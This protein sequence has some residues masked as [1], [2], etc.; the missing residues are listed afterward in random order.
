LGARLWS[1]LQAAAPVARNGPADPALPGILNVRFPGVEGESLLLALDGG[2]AASSGSACSAATA[3]PSYVLRAL[4]L[5][6]L[7]AQASLRLSLGRGTTEAE[8]DR[9]ARLLVAAVRR[10]RAVLPS[11]A[12]E[13]IA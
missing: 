6:D 1:G 11:G 5:S 10:L 8:I 13:R 7:A 12:L 3:E 2:L 9:A 4:G